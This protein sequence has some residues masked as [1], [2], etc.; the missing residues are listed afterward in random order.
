MIAASQL[1]GFATRRNLLAASASVVFLF[2]VWLVATHAFTDGLCCGDDAAIA[3][4]AKSVAEGEGYS[5]PLNFI[6]ESG[7]FPFHHGVSTGPALVFPAA[8][9]IKVFGAQIWAPSLASA[10]V[11]LGLLA[12]TAY[13]IGR[14]EGLDTAS[15]FVVVLVPALYFLT[16]NATFF[17]HWYSLLGELPAA[18]FLVLAAWFAAGDGEGAK[19][20]ARASLLAGLAAGMAVNSKLL[21][22][23]G[24]LAIGGVFALRLVRGHGFGALRDG[25]IYTLGMFLPVA[26][27]ELYRLAS[28][29]AEGYVRWLHGMRDFF[30]NQAPGTASMDAGSLAEAA[31]RFQE[32]VATTGATSLLGLLVLLPIGY[33]CVAG[34]EA[35]PARAAFAL[36]L[37][38]MSYFIW[39]LFLSNGWPRY[40]LI[41][42]VLLVVSAVMGLIPL[43]GRRFALAAIVL[44][45]CLM[46]WRSLQVLTGPVQYSAKNGF[47]ENERVTSL[48]QV[49]RYLNEGPGSD[50]VIA[51]S[52]W[53]S[54]TAVEYASAKPRVTVAFNRLYTSRPDLPG[55]LLLK[56]PRWDAYSGADKDPAFLKFAEDCT[57]QVIE[58]QEYVVYRCGS[59]P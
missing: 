56:A 36:W 30:G 41:G 3:L 35:R 4:A 6:G 42:F 34:G 12:L 18:F 44:L 59:T 31:N 52:W 20:G 51:G 23:V 7:Y 2:L 15:R 26:A 45:A 14:S 10:L 37:A 49:A 39:W 48:R 16:A 57:D 53:A 9:L 58:T 13:L 28:V 55:T 54:L 50:S 27:F 29:G 32:M 33:A 8:A 1:A 47:L 19:A 46:P 21:G 25:A 22:L 38:G 43:R 11:S 24:G 40:G 5:L 17:I